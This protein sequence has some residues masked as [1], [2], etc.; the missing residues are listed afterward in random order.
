MRKIDDIEKHFHSKA[1]LVESGCIEWQG[2]LSKLGYG[3][4]LGLV[5]G[6]RK[7]VSTHRQAYLFAYGSIPDGLHV[8][9]TCDNRKCVNP[10]HLFLGTH[11]D[12]M[13][14]MVKKGRHVAAYKGY[15]AMREKRSRKITYCKNAHEI[16]Y[17][18][19]RIKGVYLN[20]RRN[21]IYAAIQ[22]GRKHKF[23]GYFDNKTDAAIA[24]NNAASKY[25]GEYAWLNPIT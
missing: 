9:H 23:L 17:Y 4:F 12:N 25:F 18:N 1:L 10:D 7:M 24:Y 22:V 3:Q 20:K 5:L 13:R 21:I 11:A 15:Y 8:C 2:G 6:V 16:T 19:K 14:D